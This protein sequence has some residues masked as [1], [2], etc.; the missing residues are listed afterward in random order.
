MCSL[1][2]PIEDN[3]GAIEAEKKG[4]CIMNRFEVVVIG[5]GI[6]GSSVAYY[7]SKAGY[8]VALVEKG[9]IANGTS[10]RCDAVALI[11]DKKP[12]I[13]TEMGYK[14]IQLYKELAKEF[15]YDFEF[16]SRGS[17][18]VCETEQ[19]LEM[20]AGYVAQQKSAGYEMR[21]VDH[22]ELFDIEPY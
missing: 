12:G 1:P 14:S 2:E 22:K 21:M 20:A 10:S 15:S 18:Y 7:L 16:A 13:D 6:I 11:C 3:Q 5:A 8:S 9:D 17:L 4:G 19:E